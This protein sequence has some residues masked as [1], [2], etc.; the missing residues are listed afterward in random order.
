MPASSS[1]PSSTRASVAGAAS[2]PNPLAL[3]EPAKTSTS[4][5]APFSRSSQRLGI[6]GGRI[7]MVDALHHRPGGA[8]GAAGNGLGRGRALIE[9]LDGQAVIGA[10]FQPF[11]MARP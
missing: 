11:E 2:R 5:V 1:I 6:G 4:P 3:T 10:A 7:G 9:R 8:G